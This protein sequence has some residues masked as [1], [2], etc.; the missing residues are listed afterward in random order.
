MTTK[1]QKLAF[2]KTR[3]KRILSR[4]YCLPVKIRKAANEDAVWFY[5]P[6]SQ[7]G[8]IVTQD[9]FSQSDEWLEHYLRSVLGF[10]FDSNILL[11]QAV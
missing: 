6:T 11:D 5:V 10:R 1:E 9:D 4:F 7:N 8:I 3:L 2:C